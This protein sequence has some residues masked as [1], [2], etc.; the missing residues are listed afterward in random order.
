MHAQP[1]HDSHLDLDFECG[2][3]RLDGEPLN[4]ARK[5]YQL[6]VVLIQH[7]GE[8]VTRES[9][10]FQAWG[11]TNEI[12]TRTVDVHVRRLRKKLREHRSQY[13]ET[14]FGVGYRFRPFRTAQPVHI[15]QRSDPDD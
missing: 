7:R 10:M 13:I 14:I 9:L 15:I 2:I 5:E 4:L 12:R 1:Y 8:V 6:L 11:Y 3:A